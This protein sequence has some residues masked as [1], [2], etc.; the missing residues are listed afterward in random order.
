MKGGLSILVARPQ[1]RA[2]FDKYPCNFFKILL[3]RKDSP[4]LSFPHGFIHV[5]A[6]VQILNYQRRQFQTK[7]TMEV[8]GS[9]R[10]SPNYLGV[11][12]SGDP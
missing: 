3:Q 7:G 8:N 4:R 5:P 10:R 12:G 1:I 9:R 2:V 6:P 11:R